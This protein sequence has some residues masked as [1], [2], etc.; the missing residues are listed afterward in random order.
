MI[1]WLFVKYVHI[2]NFLQK[3]IPMPITRVS[4]FFV[5]LLF[6]TS[7][8]LLV[9][10]GPLSGDGTERPLG[11]SCRTFFRTFLPQV[12]TRERCHGR[13][14][15][16][17]FFFIFSFQ[18]TKLSSFRR[19]TICSESDELLLSNV[20]LDGGLNFVVGKKSHQL[21]LESLV[22]LVLDGLVDVRLRH[23]LVA[24]FGEDDR[25]T[26]FQKLGELCDDLGR[27]HC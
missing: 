13:V 4:M 12:L 11:V 3:A 2:Y 5:E 15:E 22:E 25:Q 17:F 20:V 19:K 7:V 27:R 10:F 26:T 21:S 18:K 24:T 16:I 14:E 8:E 1:K 23:L 6:K 9:K